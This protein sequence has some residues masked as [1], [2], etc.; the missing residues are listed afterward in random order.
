MNLDTLN[1]LETILAEAMRPGVLGMPG[2]K[3]EK[4]CVKDLQSYFSEL[5]SAVEG[6]KLEDKSFDKSTARHVVEHALKNVLRTKQESLLAALKVNLEAAYLLSSKQAHMAEADDEFELTADDLSALGDTAQAAAD[7]ASE[8]AG[9]LV[10]DL[11]DTS[12]GLI[13]DAV[14][15]GI[16]QQLGSTGTGQLIRKALDDMSVARALTIASTEINRAMSAAT[17]DK[18]TEMQVE[19]KQWI[20]DSDPCEICIANA[21]QGPIPIDEDF[22]SGDSYSPAHPNCRCAVAGARAPEGVSESEDEPRD[23]QGR[24]TTLGNDKK[25]YSSESV[26][27]RKPKLGVIDK[28]DGAYFPLGREDIVDPKTLTPTQ[29][30]V[31]K[32]NVAYHAKHPLRKKWG[33]DRV[34]VYQ[35]EGEDLIVD[36]HHRVAAD[37]LKGRQSKIEYVGVTPEAL[38]KLLL[39]ESEDEAR[40][41]KGE[42]TVSGTGD[43]QSLHGGKNQIDLGN[44]KPSDMPLTGESL[45]HMNDQGLYTEKKIAI[46]KLSAT[47]PTVSKSVVDKYTKSVNKEPVQ[48]V[49]SKGK[50][51]L[52]DGHHRVLAAQANGEKTITARVFKPSD[53]KK[54]IYEESD[55][56][57]RNE[58]GEWTSGG[59]VSVGDAKSTTYKNGHTGNTVIVHHDGSSVSVKHLDPKGDLLVSTAHDSVGSARKELST[60]GIKHSFYK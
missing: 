28:S 2:R 35:H 36:G 18:L 15:Q 44:T 29:L 38:K 26:F 24:W 34:K 40:N 25:S 37:I 33:G 12:T 9:D 60:Q 49:A 30:G 50:Y 8:H 7:Y 3:L 23:E 58:K 11:D 20:L 5:T 59:T 53:A 48:V 27:G 42:W 43:Q 17:I 46:S 14:E 51:F 39:G 4:Q 1:S 45:S 31:D 32:E 54:I 47:Q 6:L 56:E 22:D 16:D 57:P 10:T 13:A 52:Y 19:Y 41:E 55:D 21:A